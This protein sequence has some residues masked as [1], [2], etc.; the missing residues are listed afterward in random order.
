MK[1]HF[2]V[3]PLIAT[4]LYGLD[5]DEVRKIAS[6]P[7]SREKLVPELKI[8]P[9]AREYK[10]TA[11]SGKSAEELQVGPEIIAKEKT[12]RGRYIVSTAMLP[13]AEKPLI[14]VVTFQKETETFKKWVLLPD[15]ILGSS[16]GIADFDN[17][18][19][20]W[21]ADKADGDPPTTVLVIE[22]HSDDKSTWKDTTLQDGKVIAMSRGVAVKTK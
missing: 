4:N 22:T 6:E 2:F 17:R 10:I 13:G 11:Q 21:T 5:A 15:G 8:Y 14:M 7:H 1:L 18:T 3:I 9:G 12:V 16:T 20:A 19:I